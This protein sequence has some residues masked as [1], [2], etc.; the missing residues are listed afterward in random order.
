MS[1]K[2]VRTE[3]GGDNWEKS[4][5][6]GRF[7]RDIVIVGVVLAGG[8]G[9]YYKRSENSSMAN[10]TAKAAQ[11]LLLKDDPTAYKAAEAKLKEVLEKYD[12]SHGYSLASLAELNAILVREHKMADRK[13]AAE[14]YARKAAAENTNIAEEYSARALLMIADG[15]AAEAETYLTK[16]VVEKGGGGA[17]IFAALGEA[18]RAQGKVEE[19][20]RAFKAAFDADWRNPRFAQL[21]GESYL[22]DG[23]GAN[24]LAYFAKGLSANSEHIGCQLGAARAKILLGAGLKEAAETIVAVLGKDAELTPSL[25]ARALLGKAEIMLHEQKTD[26]AIAAAHEASQADPTFAWTFLVKA[27]AEAAKKDPNAEADFQKA[28]AADPYVSAFYFEAAR[29]L[30]AAGDDGTKAIAFLDK[31]QGKKDDRFFLEYGNTLKASGKLD[32]A[33]AKYDEAIKQNEMNAQVYVAKASVLRSQQKFADAEKTL[34]AAQAAQEFFPELYVEK[35]MLRFDKK[36]YEQGMQEYATALTQWRTAK[37]PRE[38]LTSE[39]AN[40]KDFLTK[41]GQKQ[42]AQVWEKEATDLIR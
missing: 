8:F 17:R 24:A 3:K 4:E 5:S 19:A 16:D 10:K 1:D 42:Y 18:L 14:E 25:K 33:V 29:S 12:A 20:R 9:W 35:A 21:I 41:A 28:V 31:Y 2:H 7:I 23:D 30:L 40:V 36:E 39:I 37:Q 13:G 11:E 15:K 6:G 34:E 27:R 32:E 38:K 26:E 22:E